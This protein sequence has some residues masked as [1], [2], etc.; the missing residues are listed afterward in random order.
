VL[1]ASLTV[2]VALIIGFDLPA[3]L[4]RAL[5][6]ETAPTSDDRSTHA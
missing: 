3:R 1:A 4:G 5:Q 6:P 2:V